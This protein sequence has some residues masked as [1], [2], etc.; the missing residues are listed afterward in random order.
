[1]ETSLRHACV[2]LEA[3]ARRVCADFEPPKPVASAN[4]CDWLD[5]LLHLSFA[6]EQALTVDGFVPD[7]YDELVAVLDGV[8][9]DGASI[10]EMLGHDHAE[11]LRWRRG[12]IHYA[13]ASTWVG[14]PVGL[15]EAAEA[16]RCA[17][18]AREQPRFIPACEAG[19]DVLQE[20]I[21]CAAQR[22]ADAERTHPP[23]PAL[24]SGFAEDDASAH[25]APGVRSGGSPVEGGTAGELLRMGVRSDA[26]VLAL[27]YAADML[28][29]R[30]CCAASAAA[31]QTPEVQAEPRAGGDWRERSLQCA[32]AFIVVVT[33]L[34]P[35]HV[36]WE[37]GR[38][39]ELVRRL[40]RAR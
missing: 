5:V 25:G 24:S 19:A 6:I 2:R 28:F 40:S 35:Q 16:A 8:R 37:R 26:H 12:A 32:R 14:A 36:G 34:L 18:A 21:A 27:M 11:L 15:D 13:A 7:E 1:M 33:E 31:I 39:D 22:H 9:A 23:E 30:H 4:A 29:W 38:A 20:L 17:A 10:D 3:V